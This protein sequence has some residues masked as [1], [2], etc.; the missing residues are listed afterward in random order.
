ASEWD[1]W[2]DGDFTR[3][4]SLEF[5]QAHD[6]LR[7]HW[8]C[9]ILGGASGGS[10]H[11]E[12]WKDGKV[13][14]RKCQGIIECTNATCNIIENN[15]F[16]QIVEQNPIAGPLKL[17]VGRPGIDGPG[18]SVADISPV[19]FN[20]ERIKYERRKIL[21]GPR[22]HDNFNKAFNQF[23]E[24]HPDFIREAQFGDVSVIVMQTPFMASKLVKAVV[25][26]EAVNGIVSDA[27]HRFWK[28]R[29]SLLIVSSTFVPQHL[30]CWVPGIMSYA[31]GGTAEHY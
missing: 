6:N 14:R 20:A 11:A 28:E 17:L 4:F 23:K 8:A 2:P 21:R 18:E 22:R 30:K 5:A 7:V 26:Q 27:A 31:N 25:E 13:T 3:D 10:V 12:T 19:L 15:E 29:N 9:E 16:R 1:G 24:K